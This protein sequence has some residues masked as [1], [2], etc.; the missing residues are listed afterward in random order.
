MHAAE[1]GDGAGGAEH[2]ELAR[3]GRRAQLL[4][5]GSTEVGCLELAAGAPPRL[6]S[7]HSIPVGVVVLAERHGTGRI[8]PAI[9]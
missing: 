8:S 2:L 1:G 7:S 6:A 4:G 3:T 9:Y 5:G